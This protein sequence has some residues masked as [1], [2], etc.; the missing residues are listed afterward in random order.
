MAVEKKKGG[1]HLAGQVQVGFHRLA[2]VGLAGGR[3]HA[4]KKLNGEVRGAGKK[5]RTVNKRRG[6]QKREETSWWEEKRWEEK[7]TQKSDLRFNLVF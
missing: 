1:G 7:P 4:H 2:V 5:K 6:L 3:V